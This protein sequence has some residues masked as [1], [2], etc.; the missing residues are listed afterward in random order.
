MQQ[1]ERLSCASFRAPASRPSS[2][3]RWRGPIGDANE[4]RRL[5]LGS[6]KAQKRFR[7]AQ[8]APLYESVPPKLYGGTERVV[9]YLT[10][11][12]VRRGHEVTLFASGD[13]TVAAPVRSLY[14]TGLRLSGLTPWGNSLHLPML[15]EVFDRADRF[16]LIHCHVDHWGFPFI[17]ATKTPCVTTLHGR[18]DIPELF[19]VYRYYSETPVVSIS[20]AQRKPL[21]ELN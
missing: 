2:Q 13:S 16:D 1:N 5:G 6:G 19:C 11:E 8:V 17:R 15:S 14:P 3:R 12:L 7:I 10:E 21:P 4:D 9:A 18:L 20:D